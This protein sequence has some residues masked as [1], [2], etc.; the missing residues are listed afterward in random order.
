MSSPVPAAKKIA[1][2][3]EKGPANVFP[4]PRVAV[5]TASELRNL[6]SFRKSN[7]LLGLDE[8]AAINQT[9]GNMKTSTNGVFYDDW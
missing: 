3:Q 7:N 6:E 9:C 5:L 4:T 8:Q 2:A 1:G